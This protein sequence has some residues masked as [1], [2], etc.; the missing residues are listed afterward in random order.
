MTS[1]TTHRLIASPPHDLSAALER[2]ARVAVAGRN[3]LSQ[4]AAM[5][6][7]PTKYRLFAA[8]YAAMRVLDDAV[9]VAFLSRPPGERAATRGETVALVDL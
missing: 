2:C 4:A 6:E 3:N 9:D 7:N 1:D 5:L 8:T